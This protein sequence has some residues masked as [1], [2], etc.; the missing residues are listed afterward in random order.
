[1]KQLS[2]DVMKRIISICIIIMML[3]TIIPNSVYADEGEPNQ[4]GE[5]DIDENNFPDRKFREE[6]V[7]QLD[8]DGNE[9]LSDTERI[10]SARYII[11][12]FETANTKGVELLKLNKDT[13]GGITLFINAP[14]GTKFPFK[15]FDGIKNS[16]GS[17][18][19]ITVAATDAG[20]LDLSEIN[21]MTSKIGELKIKV[22][23]KTGSIDLSKIDKANIK[24]LTI[25][26]SNEYCPEDKNKEVRLP[27]LKGIAQLPKVDSLKVYGPLLTI[28]YLNLEKSTFKKI[29]ITGNLKNINLKNSLNL[30]NLKIG[31]EIYSTQNGYHNVLKYAEIETIDLK[32]LISLKEIDISHTK[33]NNLITDKGISIRSATLYDNALTHLEQWKDLNVNPYSNSGGTMPE[34]LQN[35]QK[36][37]LPLKKEKGEYFFDMKEAVGED[38]VEQISVISEGH[39]MNYETGRI[40]IGDPSNLEDSPVQYLYI[41]NDEWHQVLLTVDLRAEKLINISDSPVKEIALKKSPV[42]KKGF[43]VENMIITLIKEDGS[44]EDI[45]YSQFKN[46]AI[47]I[48]GLGT[49]KI[50]VTHMPSGKSLIVQ[51]NTDKPKIK[52]IVEGGKGSGEYY[53][54]E[55]AEI[56][57][58]VPNGREFVKWTTRNSKNDETTELEG[59]NLRLNLNTFEHLKGKTIYLTAVTKIK[60]TPDITEDIPINEEN[61]PDKTF[62]EYLKKRYEGDIL[63]AED[64][65]FIPKERRGSFGITWK[66]FKNWHGSETIDTLMELPFGSDN[67]KGLEYF[68]FGATGTLREIAITVPTGVK[69]PI[70]NIKGAFRNNSVGGTLNLRMSRDEKTEDRVVDING[71]ENIENL[72]YLGVAYN[73]NDRAIRL[74]S[75]CN[76]EQVQIVR[77]IEYY[78]KMHRRVKEMSAP[79]IS[80]LDKIPNLKALRIQG[81]MAVDG[82][83]ELDNENLRELELIG[84]ASKLDISKLNNLVKLDIEGSFTSSP[85]AIGGPLPHTEAKKPFQVREIDVSNNSK[86]RSFSLKRA[87][88]NNII[89]GRNSELK[90]IELRDVALDAVKIDGLVNLEK[91]VFENSDKNKLIGP[92]EMDFSKN[93]ELNELEVVGSNLRNL[94]L[95]ENNKVEKLSVYRNRLPYVDLSSFDYFY[96][97]AISSNIGPAFAEPQRAKV[98]AK[99]IEGNKLVLDI[100]SVVGKK[101]LKN[102]SEIQSGWKLDE[103]RGYIEIPKWGMNVLRGSS[104]PNSEYRGFLRYLYNASFADGTRKSSMLVNLYLENQKPVFKAE[105]KE[106]R[107]KQGYKFDPILVKGISVTDVE[108]DRIL[109]TKDFVKTNTVDTKTPGEYEVTY[110]ATDSWGEKS[111]PVTIKVIVEPVTINEIYIKNKPQ[112]VEYEEWDKLNLTGLVV[113]VKTAD[114]EEELSGYE[115]IKKGIEVSPGDGAELTTEVKEVVLTHEASGK[116]TSFP[117]TVKLPASP[118]YELKVLGGVIGDGRRKFKKGEKIKIS[119]NTPLG[120]EFVKWEIKEGGK[121]TEIENPEMYATTITMGEDTTIEAVTRD[122]VPVKV[123]EIRVTRNPKKIEYNNGETLDLTDMEIAL[124]KSDGTTEL[125]KFK[126]FERKGVGTSMAHGVDLYPGDYFL[127]IFYKENN[128][129]TQIK[130][131]V[132]EDEKPKPFEGKLE[133]NKVNFPDDK[134][135]NSLV[136]SLDKNGDG[137][138]TPDE[139]YVTGDVSIKFSSANFTGLDKIRFENIKR[140]LVNAPAG[141]KFPFHLFKNSMVDRS[142]E[143]GAIKIK[144]AKRGEALP[145]LSELNTFKRLGA[146]YLFPTQN[147]KELSLDNV[148]AK[149]VQITVI[150]D[151]SRSK[152]MPNISMRGNKKVGYLYVMGP[153]HF[154]GGSLECD[155]IST[156]G[157]I[158][159]YCNVAER[160]KISKCKELQ[161]LEIGECRKRGV[162]LDVDDV[163]KLSS[164]SISNATVSKLN[165]KTADRLTKL[166]LVDVTGIKKF[167]LKNRNIS[168]LRFTNTDIES[169]DVMDCVKLK[170]LSID[171]APMK[172]ADIKH[173][174]NL[175]KTEICNTKTSEIEGLT[176]GG[177][178]YHNLQNNAL[179]FVDSDETEGYLLPV[180]TYNNYYNTKAYSQNTIGKLKSVKEAGKTKIIFDMNE[181]VG[182]KR[183]ANVEFPSGLSRRYEFNKAKGYVEIRDVNYVIEQ[184]IDYTYDFIHK[185]ASCKLEVHVDFKNH[186]PEVIA[187]DRHLFA[188]DSFNPYE[189]IV[190]EDIDGSFS[191]NQ[192]N[193]KVETDV[194]ANQAGTYY[195][196][197]KATNELGIE[198]DEKTITV[199]VEEPTVT[200]MSVSKAPKTDYYEGEKISLAD[201]AVQI[202]KNNGAKETISYEAFAAAGITVTPENG[203]AANPSKDKL[204]IT[205]EKTGVKAEVKLN[206][207]EKK[208]IKA[209]FNVPEGAIKATYKEGEK[210]E[211]QGVTALL[212]KEDGSQETIGIDEFEKRG[213]SITPANGSSLT[214]DV[215]AIVMKHKNGDSFKRN[216][217]V[218]PKPKIIEGAGGKWKKG[219]ESGLNFKSDGTYET[220]LDGGA[221]VNV[222]GKK[223][224][225]NDFTHKKGSI[226]VTLKPKYLEEL[227]LGEHSIEI[228]SAEGVAEC[229]FSIISNKPEPSPAGGNNSGDNGSNSRS[230]KTGGKAAKTGDSNDLTGKIVSILAAMA[231]MA[232]VVRRRYRKL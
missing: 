122:F 221:I 217:K 127:K 220:F 89:F 26:G 176:K 153:S 18:A 214:P 207:R 185:G 138:L 141:S 131:K 206:I 182:S 30:E 94:D 211:L 88:T 42:T 219:S 199:T 197:Y 192:E 205:H 186:I 57:A 101:N 125:V 103:E 163:P 158:G 67:L 53:H 137:Y 79:D 110:Q 120:K 196:I 135:R 126:D 41:S 100:G 105:S 157:A 229:K 92:E 230:A 54:D 151:G 174:A 164:V 168:Q 22:N 56:S 102:I 183:L 96:K 193:C 43:N 189:G 165:L 81:Q 115:I 17:I 33:L 130:I 73:D 66:D 75:P 154:T 20:M 62:R 170:N 93:T 111:E 91:F 112:K 123:V 198:S 136:K 209:E 177:V 167:A 160:I 119:A 124:V 16:G 76:V 86:L 204:I 60:G 64:R 98:K 21:Q 181:F 132:R 116:K 162:N 40:Y 114:G 78:I 147:D 213:I 159:V 6:F 95:K 74:D 45:K 178:N 15:V 218:I 171:G 39:K 113:G 32:G 142:N 63:K 134:F 77:D 145:D 28:D 29:D 36:A 143:H 128:V 24:D 10:V 117:I 231:M 13:V 166:E 224:S 106:I 11:F 82:K 202:R 2:K 191:L 71:I 107:I 25:E 84:F 203:E 65:M 8:K 195:A 180:A 232:I 155:N 12:N 216:I 38:K 7:K 188:G 5:I 109:I 68:D 121:D 148:Y 49:D 227:D 87:D 149:E 51:V 161:M 69:F 152:K 194:N 59:Q 215:K 14:A 55:I 139:A 175:E 144:N 169:L 50:N 72:K 37:L 173:G 208:V 34:R 172:T 223:L 44:E 150:D 31:G 140:M 200:E 4:V 212:T 58:N 190:A 35:R 46:N 3:V 97:L 19:Q 118:K 201:L 47:E 104:L 129:A 1:M 225:E 85:S 146:V 222:D 108:D 184:G 226:A 99:R 27:E 228:L 90:D 156:I 80:F 179:K 9:K 133:I 23:S 83:L 48:T 52:L 61:F 187:S 210:L 70:E